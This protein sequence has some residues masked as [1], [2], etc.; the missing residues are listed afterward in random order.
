[1][2]R[3]LATNVANHTRSPHP[4]VVL[5]ARAAGTGLATS[6][7]D[8]WRC[9][10]R[11]T[12]PAFTKQRVAQYAGVVVAAGEEMLGRWRAAADDVVDVDTEMTGLALDMP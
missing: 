6:D 3:I 7:G 4:M 8:L 10:R 5:A 9:Q 2:R 12:Q 1:V 11:R